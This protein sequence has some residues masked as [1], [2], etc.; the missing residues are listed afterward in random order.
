MQKVSP[1]RTIEQTKWKVTVAFE[2]KTVGKGLRDTTVCIERSS[3]I[4]VWSN[5]CF[6]VYATFVQVSRGTRIQLEF[7]MSRNAK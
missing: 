6:E 2:S 7:S 1:G 5:A 3:E 4:H